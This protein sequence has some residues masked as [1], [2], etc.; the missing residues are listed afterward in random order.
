MNRGSIV[1]HE[2]EFTRLKA[3]LE[4]TQ[5]DLKAELV[6]LI[7]RSGQQ[8]A[9]QG[10]RVDIDQTALA[11]L[12]AANIAATNGLAQ[13]V[14]EPSFST[15]FHQGTKRS[16][17]ILDVARSLSL[18]LV[19]DQSVAPGMVRW[20]VRRAA[21]CL[22]EIFVNFQKKLAAGNVSPVATEQVSRMFSDEELD[23]LFERL[24]PKPDQDRK[25]Q[26]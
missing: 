7:D 16:I 14:G 10:P 6:L 20:K 3:I 26:P 15:L 13:V 18:V 17:H 1:L 12:A 2:A 25:A 24:G 23:E 4:S 19:F 22:D 21:A 9:S 8:I 11:T 5:K